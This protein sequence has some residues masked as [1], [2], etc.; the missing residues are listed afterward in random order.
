[1]GIRTKKNE[2]LGISRRVRGRKVWHTICLAPKR[3]PQKALVVRPRKGLQFPAVCFDIVERRNP[4]KPRS[5]L[6]I[7]TEKT[8]RSRQRFRHPYRLSMHMAIKATMYGRAGALKP[9]LVQGKER[10]Y[11]GGP[12]AGMKRPKRRTVIC[13]FVLSF[14]CIRKKR[15][16]P[17]GP[18]PTTSTMSTS[19]TFCGLAR[20]GRG[21]GAGYAL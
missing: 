2:K 17:F 6:Q 21:C 11:D 7:P 16:C 3:W 9:L 4:Q 15:E 1:M 10:K 18:P 5:S 19:A 12:A 8:T 13:R 14:F 20:K